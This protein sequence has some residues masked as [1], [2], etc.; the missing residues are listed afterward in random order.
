MGICEGEAYLVG[1]SMYTSTGNYTNNFQNINGCDSSVITFLTVYQKP[2]PLLDTAVTLCEEKEIMLYPGS[3]MSYEWSDGS[4]D[5]ALAINE[6]GN[7]YVTVSDSNLCYASD[8]IEIVEGECT[9]IFI[10]N[11]FTP[12]H[13]GLNDY[14]TAIGTYIDEFSMQIFD[15]WGALIYETYEYASAPN[16]TKG[17]NGE[18]TIQGN[19]VWLITYTISDDKGRLFRK[20]INGSV[21]LLR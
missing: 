14:F 4:S 18:N 16:E 1:G 11:T 21:S 20:R 6:T 5:S 12:N 10:P 3:F 17:W 13:D 8:S 15:Y 7:Y 2:D 19:Y 9:T